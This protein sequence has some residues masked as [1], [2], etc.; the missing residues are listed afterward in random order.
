MKNRDR[1]INNCNQYDLLVKIQD[2]MQNKCMCVIEAL[3]GKDVCRY[4]IDAPN[5][6]CYK[7][8]DNWLNKEE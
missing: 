8:I 2:A 3:S 5:E 4:S 7:C 6:V 1:Y